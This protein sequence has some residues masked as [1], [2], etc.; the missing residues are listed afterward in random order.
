MQISA[1]GCVSGK[2]SILKSASSYFKN[3]KSLCAPQTKN[4]SFGNNLNEDLFV[5]DDIPAILENAR[6]IKERT[7]DI[8]SDAQFIKDEAKSMYQTLSS[9]IKEGKENNFSP[10]EDGEFFITFETDRRFQDPEV[11]KIFILDK[12]NNMVAEV[13]AYDSKP[14]SVVTK[15]NGKFDAYI[16]TSNGS[17]AQYYKDFKGSVFTPNKSK[18]VLDDAFRFIE[19]LN[20]NS[21][22]VP[23]EN[24]E[25]YRK[26][27]LQ[28]IVDFLDSNKEI[29]TKFEAKES[30]YFDSNYLKQYEKGLVK[31]TDGKYKA[32]ETFKFSEHRL[33]NYYKNFEQ[34]LNEKS[35]I[36]E[37]YRFYKGSLKSYSK[38]YSTSAFGE[39]FDAQKTVTF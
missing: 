20:Q 17:L 16:F 8:K 15:D 19:N 29:T 37:V 5:K 28:T 14:Q 7:V 33:T 30:Y 39:T 3:T 10:M 21:Y 27:A 6:E 18:K 26:R 34:E 4:V 9:Y 24:V 38:N 32:K 2:N 35:K 12:F 25:F 1:L 11:Q 31:T 13:N 36:Q 22:N 23:K